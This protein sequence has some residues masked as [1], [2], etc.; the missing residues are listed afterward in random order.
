MRISWEAFFFFFKEIKAL[1]LY[2]Y[3]KKLNQDLW[4][5]GYSPVAQIWV[6]SK[7]PFLLFQNMND[8]LAQLGL[9]YMDRSIDNG[10]KIGYP[11][12]IFYFTCVAAAYKSVFLL[13]DHRC[14]ILIAIISA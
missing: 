4:R 8:P 14:Q 13:T 7:Q 11:I 6:P 1:A 10:Q 2:L 5:L 12:L 9:S 3:F